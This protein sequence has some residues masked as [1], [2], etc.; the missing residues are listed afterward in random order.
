MR[1]NCNGDLLRFLRLSAL[2]RPICQKVNKTEVLFSKALMCQDTRIQWRS[3]VNTEAESP[4][5]T[6]SHELYC[7][8]Y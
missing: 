8:V 2:M 3:L 5:I 6:A 7:I 1:V 4:K